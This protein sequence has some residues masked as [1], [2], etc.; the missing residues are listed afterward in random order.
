MSGTAPGRRQIDAGLLRR[1]NRPAAPPA[2]ADDQVSTEPPAAP[3]VAEEVSQEAV[4]PP[5]QQ[6]ARTT[7]LRNNSRDR[8]TAR[9]STYLSPSIRDRAR[10][11]Y[12]ATA[13][14]ENDRSWSAFVETALLAETSR[15]EQAHNDG[16]PFP[17]G[18]Q[19]LAPGRP[20][21]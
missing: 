19:P 8:E 4:T 18:D 16:Q 10:A 13:H 3:P 15:R 14:L 6:A 20:I 1:Q 21:N 9:M 5:A 17:G 11:A 7:T 2:P 12:R